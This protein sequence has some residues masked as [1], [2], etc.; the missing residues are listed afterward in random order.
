MKRDDAKDVVD[1]IRK[2]PYFRRK[3]TELKKT[4]DLM[5]EQIDTATAPH[6]PQGIENIGA[7]RVLSFAGKEAYL[8]FKIKEMGRYEEKLKRFSYR[9]DTAQTNF[10]KLLE[11]AEDKEFVQDYFSG[12]YSSQELE[13]KHSVTKAYRKIVGIVMDSL[14]D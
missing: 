3:L 1:E 13:R 2:I 11:V 4:V 7:A 12:K 9:Y 10:L 6:S 5:Q 14:K 8:N